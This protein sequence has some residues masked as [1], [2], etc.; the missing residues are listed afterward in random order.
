MAMESGYREGN[1]SMGTQLISQDFARHIM[2]QLGYLC[3]G[4]EAPSPE[5]ISEVEKVYEDSQR[6]STPMFDYCK[7]GD[8]CKAFLMSDRQWFRNILEQRFGIGFK[9]IIK[10]GPAIIDFKDNEEA[11]HMMRAHPSRD[12]IS[13]FRPLKKPA[14]WDN[15][16][17]KLYT[18][19][20]HQTDQEFEKSEGKDAHEV[21][22]D[23][24]QCLFVEGGLYVRLSP[25]GGTRM[26]WQ[27]F[28]VH[29]MLGDIENPKGLPFMKI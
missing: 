19:S 29:P 13:V 11:E 17:F 14:K 2:Q 27:G 16:L 26:V 25:K 10:Q 12:A 4:D 15:G 24:E 22:V 18:L 28:S 8:E 23:P 7:G 21:V 5:N 9:H 20:H 3:V 1:L 6:C